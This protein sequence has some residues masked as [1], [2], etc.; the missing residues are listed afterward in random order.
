LCKKTECIEGIVHLGV[1]SPSSSDARKNKMLAGTYLLDGQHRCKAF[2]ISQL[3]ECL[4]DVRIVHFDTMADMGEEFVRLNSQ[5]VKFGPDDI[6]RGLEAASPVLNMIRSNCEY[7]GYDNVKRNTNGRGAIVGMSMLIRSWAASSMDNPACSRSAQDLLKEMDDTSTG[8]LVAFLQIAHSAWGRDPENWRLWSTL[9]LTM[10]MWLYRR[11][12]VDRERGTRR[13]IVL[14]A[15]LFRKCLMSLSAEGNYSD[16]LLGRHM[17]E[18]DRG[19]CYNRIKTIFVRRL[20]SELHGKK[21][22]MPQPAWS[23]P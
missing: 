17:N 2:E 3:K 8:N 11:L 7:V 12:V 18:R 22:L 5:L 23:R 4:A 13:Y 1:L 14:N 10:C 20:N 16:W 6:L 15:D 19:P 9:N 21:V